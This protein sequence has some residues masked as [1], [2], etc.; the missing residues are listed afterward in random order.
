MSRIQNSAIEEMAWEAFEGIAY[1]AN[2]YDLEKTLARGFLGP[3][4][5]LS[6]CEGRGCVWDW[7]SAEKVFSELWDWDREGFYVDVEGTIE[8]YCEEKIAGRG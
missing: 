6:V 2:S 8:R 7:I 4:E 5:C 3:V 1:R